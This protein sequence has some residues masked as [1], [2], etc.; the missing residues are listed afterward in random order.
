[1]PSRLLPGPVPHTDR[2]FTPSGFPGSS[3]TQWPCLPGAYLPIPYHTNRDSLGICLTKAL[4]L[5]LAPPSGCLHLLSDPITPGP[6]LHCDHSFPGS[7]LPKARSPAPAR[8]LVGPSAAGLR[9]ALR[10]TPSAA[11]LGVPSLRVYGCSAVPAGGPHASP[12]GLSALPQLPPRPGGTGVP[13]A[14]SSP[15]LPAP[16]PGLP[17]RT[18]LPL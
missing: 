4:H 10:E 14:R 12:N 18:R 3:R 11:T 5:S 2:P 16:F 17:R 15:P 6:H 13:R 8:C 7:C 9:E 1:M